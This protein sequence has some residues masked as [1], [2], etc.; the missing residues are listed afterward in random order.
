MDVF[1]IDEFRPRPDLDIG[2]PA[3]AEHAE[4]QQIGKDLRP[5]TG[6]TLQQ[7][8]GGV[9]VK[10]VRQPNVEDQQRHGDAEYAIAEGI[11][12]RF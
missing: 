11:E 2:K 6:E 4:T 3:Q 10:I 1:P 9:G 12:A 7:F 8:A 5:Q